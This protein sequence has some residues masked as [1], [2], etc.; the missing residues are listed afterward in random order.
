MSGSQ[1]GTMKNKSE[2]RRVFAPLNTMNDHRSVYQVPEEKTPSSTEI[3]NVY[4]QQK[5]G[6]NQP[7]SHYSKQARPQ[8]GLSF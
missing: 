8:V 4:G 2:N 6:S 3:S 7:K 5:S 1:H